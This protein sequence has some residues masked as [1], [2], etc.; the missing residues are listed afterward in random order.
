MTLK[1]SLVQNNDDGKNQELTLE[2]KLKT[3]FKQS[4]SGW[5]VFYLFFNKY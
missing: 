2:K 3:P 1:Y 4:Q 5:I